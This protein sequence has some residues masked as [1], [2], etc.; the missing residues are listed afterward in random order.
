[1]GGRI[2]AD[3][4]YDTRGWKRKTYNRWWDP[5]TQ[6]GTSLV[7]PPGPNPET[8][9]LNEDSYTYDGLGRVVLDDSQGAGHTI[10]TTIT[11]YT[12]DST[13][14]IPNTTYSGQP[15]MVVPNTGGITQTTKTDPLGRT[16]ELDQ[17]TA[18]P[19]LHTP[20]DPFTGTWSITGGTTAAT[21][22][23]YDGNGNQNTVTGPAT[24]ADPAGS[25]WTSHYNLLG[26]V[27][28]KDDPDA[29]TSSMQYDPAGNLTQTTSPA[30]KTIS[31]S[32]RAVRSAPRTGRHAA[33]S[34]LELLTPVSSSSTPSSTRRPPP[35]CWR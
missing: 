16:T 11:V 24:A 15:D 26:Q 19:T 29:G 10:S 17:Y 23:G 28:S 33:C 5:N 14:V 30:S 18:P 35:T 22:Y 31:C 8:N 2:V 6:P 7:T 4:F 12:G 25:T 9:I 27:T 13:T 21:R 34:V 3:I 20:T 32:V 1:L